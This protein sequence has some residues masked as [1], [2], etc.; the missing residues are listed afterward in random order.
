MIED[1]IMV[2]GHYPLLKNQSAPDYLAYA[3]F[4]IPALASDR[5]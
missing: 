2:S 5:V 4:L 1:A 3:L